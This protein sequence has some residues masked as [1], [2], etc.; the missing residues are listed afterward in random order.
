MSAEGDVFDLMAGRYSAKTTSNFGVYLKGH[1]G[2]P[3]RVD[4]VGR[5][6]EFVLQPALTVGLAVQP[7]VIP[8]GLRQKPE[9][10]GR[11]LLARFPLRTTYQ[12]VG[13]SRHR[14]SASS[15][16]GAQ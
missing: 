10:R 7:D 13:T 15:R 4:R 9:F 16:N 2:D 14:P 8:G 1:A 5:P 11:G 3:L 6:P 12:S